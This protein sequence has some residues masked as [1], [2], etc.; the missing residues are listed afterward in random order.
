G[1]EL[2]VWAGVTREDGLLIAGGVT[3]GLGLG[4]LLAAWPLRGAE[5]NVVGGSF[6]VSVAVGFL[7]VAALGHWWRR[8]QTWGWITAA[9]AGAVGGALM[10]GA[11]VVAQFIEWGGAAALLAAGAVVGFRWLRSSR[12]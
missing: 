4:I 10:A 3:S 7:C 9:V 8:R 2:L 6:V 11:E 12:A 1:I 5:P